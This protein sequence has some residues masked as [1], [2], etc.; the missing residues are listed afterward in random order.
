MR[1]KQSRWVEMSSRLLRLKTVL[2]RKG[3]NLNNPWHWAR[4]AVLAINFIRRSVSNSLETV[5][6]DNPALDG[7]VQTHARIWER[8]KPTHAELAKMRRAIP[9]F[10]NKYMFSV[11]IPENDP[12]TVSSL[13]KQVYDKFEI[14]A[15]GLED[16]GKAAGDYALF[17][18]PGDYLHKNALFELNFE[19]NRLGERPPFVYFDHDYLVG[20]VVDKP[21]YKPEWSPDLF[22]VHDYIG[23]ACLFRRDLLDKADLKGLP[24]DSALRSMTLKCAGFGPGRHKPGILLTMPS[25][26]GEPENYCGPE[27]FS[28]PY[29]KFDGTGFIEDPSP[30][31]C[32]QAGSPTLCPAGLKK[33]IILKL[34]H[35]GD[36]V[37]SLPAI[38]KIRQILPEARI[39]V[40]CATWS[41]ELLARQPE[42]DNVFTY[43]CF[44]VQSGLRYAGENEKSR[45][46]T[47]ARLKNEKY[48]LAVNLR[49]FPDTKWLTPL[50]ADFCL[51]F[52][53]EAETDAVSHPVPA[54]GRR[55]GSLVKWSIRDQL[56]SLAGVLE[57]DETLNR[58]VAVSLETRNKVDGLIDALPFF[59]GRIIIG[60]H[61]GS[62]MANKKWPLGH[63]VD[64]CL[65]IQE[66]TSANILLLG[67]REDEADNQAIIGAV[68]EKDRVMSVAGIF[69]LVEFFHLVKKLDYFVGNDSGPAHIAGLQGVSTLVIFGSRH[70][71]PEW[72]PIGNSLVVERRAPCGP[73]YDYEGC[74][75]NECLNRITPLEVW[76]SL[77]RLMILYPSKRKSLDKR[78]G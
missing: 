25:S 49:K 41:R 13:E 38:R 5:A 3:V 42:I 61:V 20:G 29:L 75:D 60:M 40:L 30:T 2:N 6:L 37:L 44:N 16:R 54:I 71:S 39:D 28:N 1:L 74:Q 4:L 9:N 66:R 73:C 52:S 58:E 36:V 62:G 63:F 68:R 34:D 14:I 33:V 35:I 21:C 57:F 78:H 23:R 53:E 24:F 15:G 51:V 27:V 77:E 69:S 64:L 7:P 72:A 12:E 17:L 19:L 76:A 26:P 46:E 70:P 31:L 45:E 43:D 55:T 18:R 8:L 47:L 50:L 10:K 22:S 65:L 56:L 67:S 48:D 32:R 11:I 59:Q